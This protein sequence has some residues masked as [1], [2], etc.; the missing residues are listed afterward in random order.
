MSEPLEQLCQIAPD[1]GSVCTH[2]PE[3]GLRQRVAESDLEAR[4]FANLGPPIPYTRPVVGPNAEQAEI[5]EP[6]NIGHQIDI[7]ER[8]AGAEDPRDQ[9]F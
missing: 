4:P 9:F 5:V 2:F 6:C 3:L 1:F 8:W 7:G